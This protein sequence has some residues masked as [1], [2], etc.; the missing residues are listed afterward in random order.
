MVEA[1]SGRRKTRERESWWQGTTTS[2]VVDGVTMEIRRRGKQGK[3]GGRF[4]SAVHGGS[5]GFPAIKKEWVVGRGEGG[6][7]VM[8]LLSFGWCVR[9]EVAVIS[10][11][12]KGME[13]RRWWPETMGKGERGVLRRWRE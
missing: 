3:S 13:F 5:G 4:G 1:G 12:R 6:K 8:V 2:A 11:R 7:R 10:E 9:L